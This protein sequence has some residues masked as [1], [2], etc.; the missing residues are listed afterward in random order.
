MI[1]ENFPDFM[2]SMNKESPIYTNFRI[3]VNDKQ[4]VLGNESALAFKEKSFLASPD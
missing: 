3:I 4:N 2:R 1:F